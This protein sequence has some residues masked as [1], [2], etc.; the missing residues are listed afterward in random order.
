MKKH[1]PVAEL[2]PGDTLGQDILA[3]SQVLLRQGTVLTDTQIDRLKRLNLPGIAVTKH[4]AGASV[5]PPSF[6][7]LTSNDQPG[8]ISDAQ[9][10]L[11][12]AAEPHSVAERTFQERKTT[13]R[14][15]AGLKPLIDPAKDEEITRRLEAVFIQSAVQQRVF[16]DRLDAVATELA[17]AFNPNGTFLDF[18]ETPRH[19]NFTDISRYGQHLVVASLQSAK[20]FKLLTVEL[21]E[22]TYLTHI[23]AHLAMT[24]VF[25]QLPAMLYTN[26]AAAQKTGP[27]LNE[28]ITQYAAW[29][30]GQ[31]YVPAPVLELTRQRVLCQHNADPGHTASC[32]DLPAEAQRMALAGFYCEQIYSLPLRPRLTPHDAAQQV[33]QQ[34]ERLFASKE[35]NLFLHRLGYYP[36]GSL[37]EL[38]DGMLALVVKQNAAALLKPIVQIIDAEGNLNGEQDLTQARDLYIRRQVLEY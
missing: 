28:V 5:T 21:P 9:F 16:L 3:G 12:V 31:N 24:N 38:S 33:V 25:A 7:N 36:L 34:S 37:V 1:I 11:P 15:Q 6:A 32:Q 23:R 26:S 4:T 19:L 2:E 13:L 29:L 8:W 35:V 20:M 17:G 30:T 22:A 10:S 27:S 14:Q 18:E